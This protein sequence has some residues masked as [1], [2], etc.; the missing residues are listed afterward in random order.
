M[1]L[2]AGVVNSGATGMEAAARPSQYRTSGGRMPSIT[3]R[4]TIEGLPSYINAH[5]QPPVSIL[6]EGI[7]R[8]VLADDV[9]PSKCLSALMRASSRGRQGTLRIHSQEDGVSVLHTSRPNSK[10]L[11][12]FFCIIFRSASL[13]A[14]LQRL[15]P[16][17]HPRHAANTG[18]GV[19]SNLA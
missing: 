19:T 5:H 4:N 7:E 16:S 1:C 17:F 11:S 9:G 2:R 8:N 12:S 6:A 18:H 14:F 10:S 15:F 13:I 3:G